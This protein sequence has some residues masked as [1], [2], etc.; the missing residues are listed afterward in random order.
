[1]ILFPLFSAAVFAEGS[2]SGQLLKATGK[3]LPYTE[4]ELVPRGAKQLV[5]DPKLIGISDQSGRFSFPAVPKGRYT[6]SINFDDKPTELS[7][8]ATYFYP[9]TAQRSEGEVF[10]ITDGVRIQKLIFKLPPPLAR[11]KITGKVVYADG[12]PVGGAWLAVRDV[13][14]DRGISFGEYRTNKLGD[15]S[16]LAFASRKYQVAA[17][18][19]ERIGTT[20]LDPYE[21]IG[22]AESE[23]FTLETVPVNLKLVL[24]QSQNYDQLREKYIGRLVPDYSIGIFESRSR[25][26]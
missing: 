7:P 3:P 18:L 16:F 5:N 6:L 2:I 24:K 17:I 1:M 25:G 11:R 19:L 8:Y 15:F 4:L 26:E 12:K 10:D 22:A 9:G 23:V 20:A 13:I 14:F 21:F